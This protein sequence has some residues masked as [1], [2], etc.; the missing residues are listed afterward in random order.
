MNSNP[1][2]LNPSDPSDDDDLRYFF[3]DRDAETDPSVK[4]LQEALLR[5][6]PALRR[7]IVRVFRDDSV[8]SDYIDRLYQRLR[9]ALGSH[10]PTDSAIW[11]R[12]VSLVHE[13]HRRNVKR[14]GSPSEVDDV[15]DPRGLG[16]SDRP[17]QTR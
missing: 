14:F 8:V 4:Q 2:A 6:L 15:A 13:D 7:H 12:L 3:L 1:G 16:V 11:R 17:G 9:K 10:E 5:N